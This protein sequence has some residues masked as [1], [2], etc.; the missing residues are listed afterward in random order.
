MR[1]DIEN[2]LSD[3]QAFTGSAT[4]STNSYKK[5]TAAQDI[6][7]GRRMAIAVF[8]SAAGAGTTHTLE[9]IQADNAALTSNVESLASVSID[10][11]DINLGYPVEVPIPQ[12]VMDKQYLGFRHT[13]SSGTTTATIDAF[14]M[15]QDEITEKFKGFPKAVD[16]DV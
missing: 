16:A 12:G 3:A 15:P 2:Q 13:A 5:Q 11:D 7:I 14:L 8:F 6:S 9:A 1:F 10:T 4:V